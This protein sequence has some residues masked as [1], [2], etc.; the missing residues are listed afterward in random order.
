MSLHNLAGTVAGLGCVEAGV[1]YL[2]VNQNLIISASGSQKYTS[3]KFT[4]ILST[5]STHLSVFSCYAYA[6]FVISII[7]I[8]WLRLM[9]TS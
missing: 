1:R 3:D 9:M 6:M 5:L 4:H 7:G 2:R 8:E